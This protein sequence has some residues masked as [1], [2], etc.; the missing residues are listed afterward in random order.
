MAR[1]ADDLV[2]VLDATGVER[3]VITGHSMGAFVAVAMA[4]RHPDR[5]AGLILIDGGLPLPLPETHNDSGIPQALLGPAAAR[6][7]MTFADRESYRA[8]WRVHPAFTEEWNATVEDYVDY[9]LVGEEPEMHAA[10]SVDAVAFDSR[11]LNGDDTYREALHAMQA[12]VEFLRAPRGLMNQL[13]GLYS[14]KEISE[15]REQ[16][17]SLRVHEVAD[18]NHYTIIMTTRGAEAVGRVITD[19]VA[20]RQPH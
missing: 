18:V 10:S 7:A 5:V 13:P 2:R 20:T 6:L 15:W 9:D 16:L 17:P 11:Q 19:V 3:A 8:F 4:H 1:H 14:P 12:P